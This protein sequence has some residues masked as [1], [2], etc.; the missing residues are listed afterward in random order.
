MKSKII[1]ALAW[2]LS[3]IPMLPTSFGAIGRFGLE[4]KTRKCTSI[5]MNYDGEPSALDPKASVG[6][7]TMVVACILLAT[8]NGAIYY[9]LM[10]K[11]IRNY[12]I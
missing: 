11:R 9:R 5:N 1:I 3:F 2:I 6:V 4:C 10:V 8:L 7:Y 12:V